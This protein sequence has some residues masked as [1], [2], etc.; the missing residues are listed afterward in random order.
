MTTLTPA[1]D[2]DYTTPRSMR[3]PGVF[4]LEDKN[5]F[6]RQTPFTSSWKLTLSQKGP[7]SEEGTEE[8]KG[9]TES[10]REK[11]EEPRTQTQRENPNPAAPPR[12]GNT[13]PF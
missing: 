8:T 11:S 13:G 7:G 6:P 4:G 2:S 10:E 5:F 3:Q 12:R 9:K 1:D